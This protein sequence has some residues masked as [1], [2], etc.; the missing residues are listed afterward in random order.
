MRKPILFL[1]AAVTAGAMGCKGPAELP[2]DLID[3]F[4]GR[5][6]A[7]ECHE[8][9]LGLAAAPTE[10]RLSTDSTWTLLDGPQLQIL[11]FDD[12]FRQV[13]RTAV[14]AVGPGAAAN[15]VSVAT[16]GD[17]A[18]AVAARGGLR[19]VILGRDGSGIRSESLDFIPHSLEATDDGR[20]LVTGM[21]FGTKPPTLLMR[22]TGA[23]WDTLAV[24]KRTYPDMTISALGNSALV[25]VL[26]DGRALLVHQFLRPRAFRV[27][28]LDLVETLSL[29][30]PDG[31]RDNIDFVPRPPITDDQ[32][33]H[34]LL[35]ATAM[36]VD[37]IRSEVYVLT[38][39]GRSAG[40]H[41]ER[42]ILRLTADLEFME[43]YTLAVPA[44][45]MVYLPRRH[46]VVVVDGEDRFH[47]C[48]LPE[49]GN[50]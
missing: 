22:Y 26:P 28:P 49:R 17:T 42:A 31:T 23:G 20:I 3:D 30:T 13:S 19:L 10:I 14:P 27:G 29:P 43:G 15:P 7:L 41:A 44:G 32:L 18:F 4:A 40:G 37:P 5:S 25:E 24:P 1:L 39:S 34:T 47:Q 46:S 6:T 11:E 35:P 50:E 36:T 45:L 21:P 8:L 16:L 38:R 48:P 2:L 33:P 12:A 9:D